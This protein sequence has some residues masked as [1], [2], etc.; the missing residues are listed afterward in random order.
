MVG[1]QTTFK[2]RAVVE[3]VFVVAEF[4]FEKPLWAIFFMGLF[5]VRRKV[6]SLYLDLGWFGRTLLLHRGLPVDAPPE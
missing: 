4:A 6:Q 2:V 1:V 5:S 3:I